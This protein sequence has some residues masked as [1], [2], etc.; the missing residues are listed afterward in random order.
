VIGCDVDNV[1]VS[2]TQSV[3]N[4]HFE[5]TG[6]RLH[7][8]DIKSYYI[9][10]YVSDKYKE[11]FYKIFLDKRVWKGIDILPN[12]VETIKRLH[13]KGNEIYF[14]TATEML[15]VPKK[16]GFLQRTFPF[17]NIRKRFITTQNKQMIKCDIL[18]DDYEKN[19]IGGDYY[20]LLMNYPWNKNFDDAEHD[21]IYRI[22]DWTQVE[23]MVDIIESLQKTNKDSKEGE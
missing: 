11:D 16:A 12:C 19:L 2:T 9:E 20:G 13:D 14:I 15:N 10:D 5:D 1:I 21:N 17:L 18:I 22:Y 23:A 3:L 4:V 6:E 7:L 8:E